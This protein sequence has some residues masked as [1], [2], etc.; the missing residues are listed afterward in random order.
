[1]NADKRK[2]AEDWLKF[3]DSGQM[4]GNLQA[5]SL[6]LVAYELLKQAIVDEIGESYAL[7]MDED[8]KWIPSQVYS[9]EVIS[10]D[11]RKRKDVVYASCL[12]LRGEGGITDADIRKFRKIRRHRNEIAHE[13]IKYLSSSSHEINTQLFADMFELLAKIDRWWIVNFHVPANPRFDG[14]QI[15]E[16]DVQSGRMMVL[17][18]IMQ[19]LAPNNEVVGAMRSIFQKRGRPN[20]E[21]TRIRRKSNAPTKQRA[22]TPAEATGRS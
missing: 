18:L 2:V 10:L 11:R 16:G 20:T 19:V 22:P 5:A 9:R 3:L 1:M 14:K 4:R 12:W 15:R 17:G 7:E 8:G 6:F 21:P 13:L